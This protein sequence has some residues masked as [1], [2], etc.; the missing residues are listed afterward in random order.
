MI[1][2]LGLR[3]M[4]TTAKAAP[5]APVYPAGV[6]ATRDMFKKQESRKT[7]LMDRYTH[8][9][10]TKSVFLVYHQNAQLYRD[11]AGLKAAIKAAGGEHS[12]IATSLMRATLRGLSTED[13]LS[14][15]ANAEHKNSVHPLSQLFKG[16][17][18]VVSFD[19]LDPRAVESV[20]KLTDR[21]GD[22]MLLVGAFVN[23]Q[24]MSIDEVDV[25]KKLPSM[26]DLHAQL[27][28]L[29]TVLGGGQLVQ[30]LEAP[31]KLLYLN[32][33]QHAKGEGEGEKK[34]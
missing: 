3:G 4:A 17:A 24:T 19:K 10:R 27:A 18:S 5:K 29:L 23:G 30:A 28:G 21:V 22:R 1:S 6:P 8:M 12:T 34:E 32:L 7:Y 25:L 14:K 16:S 20:I 9:L 31:G 11:Q 26:E 15:Q 33:D 2:R 13:P